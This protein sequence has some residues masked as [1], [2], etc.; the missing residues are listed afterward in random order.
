M[1]QIPIRLGP[2]A[3]L[4]TVIS[5]C[6]TTLSILTFTT[7]RADM[8]LSGRY[9]DTITN[10]YAV[11]NE[12]EEFL[13]KFE[14]ASR[15]G[16]VPDGFEGAKIAEDGSY[17]KYIDQEGIT[18]HIKVRPEADGVKI[19]AWQVTKDWAQNLDPGNLWPGQ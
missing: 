16:Q 13:R 15:T 8:R 3:L 4:L 7:S 19:L 9:A 17:E 14:D 18:L 1:N 5:I 6:L 10:R 11:M 12:G 2:L